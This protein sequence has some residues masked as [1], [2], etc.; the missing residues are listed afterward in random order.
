MHK[1]NI[2]FIKEKHIWEIMVFKW[3]KLSMKIL[4]LSLIVFAI[5]DLISLIYLH[6]ISNY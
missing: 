1:K 6:F 2:K 4:F 5:I 3:V